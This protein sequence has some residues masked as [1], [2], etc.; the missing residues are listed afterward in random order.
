MQLLRFAINGFVGSI[1]GGKIPLLGEISQGDK[2]VV[3]CQR[4][5]ALLT[6]GAFLLY[7][8]CLVSFF[9]WVNSFH[10]RRSPSLSDGGLVPL[11][12]LYQI[13]FLLTAKPPQ[14]PTTIVEF[15]IYDKKY[16]HMSVFFYCAQFCTLVNVLHNPWLFGS[17]LCSVGLPTVLS[18][19][20]S[21]L[22]PRIATMD[23]SITPVA[24]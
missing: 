16:R 12:F 21:G 1:G 11:I 5:S 8:F 18:L 17:S 6:E 2:R 23:F 15:S 4:A 20:F 9:G 19:G 24:P 14:N 13:N 3:L 10:R 22:R 7:S